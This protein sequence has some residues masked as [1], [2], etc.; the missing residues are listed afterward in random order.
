MLSARYV[1]PRSLPAQTRASLTM[2]TITRTEFETVEVRLSH[3]RAPAAHQFSPSLV[4][5]TDSGRDRRAV[6]AGRAHRGLLRV[7]RAA[8]AHGGGDGR[9]VCGRLPHDRPRL[10]VAVVG[11]RPG[12][13]RDCSGLHGLDVVGDPAAPRPLPLRC[14]RGGRRRGLA[15]ARRLHRRATGDGRGAGAAVTRSRRARPHDFPCRRRWRGSQVC[16]RRC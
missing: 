5:R 2:S 11:I 1:P 7:D 9:R 6:C 13:R 15:L 3:S 16:S 4:R 10:A 8:A 14:T 12:G